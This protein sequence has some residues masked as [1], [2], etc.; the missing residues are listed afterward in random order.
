M[1]QAFSYIG[2]TAIEDKLQERVP[3]VIA[4][5][6]ETKIRLWVLT[7]DKQETAIEIAKSCKLIQTDMKVVILTSS[8]LEEL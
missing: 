8:T 1:E 7:G 4:K 6:I 5:I 3:E 2:S